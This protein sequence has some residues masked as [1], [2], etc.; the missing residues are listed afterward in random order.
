MALQSGLS[1]W[2]YTPP[3]GTF[4]GASQVDYSR[5]VESLKFSTI[6]PGGFGQLSCT[7]KVSDSREQRPELAL[8][9]RIAVM[10]QGENGPYAVFIGEISDPEISFDGINGESW[11]IQ[12]LGIGNCLRDDPSNFSYVTQTAKQ[13][14]VAQIGY[15]NRPHFLPISQDTTQIF[16]DNPSATYSPSYQG[17]SIQDIIGDVCTVTG[18]YAWGVWAHETQVDSYGFPLGQLVIHLRNTTTTN[19]EAYLTDIQSWKVSPTAERAYNVIAVGYNDP[20]NGNYNVQVYNDPRL[21]ANGTQQTAP[22][23]RRRFMQDFSGVQTINQ[24]QATKIANTFGA[25]MQNVQNKVQVVL[26]NCRNSNGQPIPL[27]T[28]TADGNISIPGLVQRALLLSTSAQAAVNQFYIISAEYSEDSS[29][30]Q[31]LTLQCDNWF[32]YA[33]KRIARLQ[34]KAYNQ[35]S[36]GTVQSPIISSGSV[37]SGRCGGFQSN[38]AASGSQGAAFSYHGICTNAPTSVNLSN[39]ASVNASSPA[40][41]SIT[42]YGAQVVWVATGA[43]ATNYVA[44]WTTVGNCL[45]AVDLDGGT[46]DHHCDKCDTVRTAL[47]ILEHIRVSA[48]HGS[49]APGLHALSVDCPTCGTVESFNTALTAD[50]EIVSEKNYTR[51]A[52]MAALIRKMQSH[53]PLQD[54]V[55]AE[56]ARVAAV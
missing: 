55:R 31:T 52:E 49:D 28:V 8:F 13:I 11:N 45:L 38:A 17:Y 42:T 22:F 24:T 16:P 36:N 50:D 18:D 53:G 54:A 43:G 56:A 6:S 20:N 46:F 30:A 10:A 26:R 29:G 27:W 23:R 44:E 14:V 32:D 2:C 40:V 1:V 47:P 3:G 41:T 51:R 7:I 9:S 12:A 4:Y 33:Q 5:A 34:M 19:Y 25:E 35:L 37:D 48:P 39:V 15:I 21:A